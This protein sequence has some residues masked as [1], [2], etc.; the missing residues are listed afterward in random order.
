[1]IASQK[2]WLASRL[3]VAFYDFCLPVPG[4]GDI[5]VAQKL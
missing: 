3:K 4:A 5:S 1:M 2:A